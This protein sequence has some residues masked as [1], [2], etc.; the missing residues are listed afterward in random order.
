MNT[1]YIG[2]MCVARRDIAFIIS[3]KYKKR[4][5]RMGM[6]RYYPFSSDRPNR[7]IPRTILKNPTLPSLIISNRKLPT[8]HSHLEFCAWDLGVRL[9]D[10]SRTSHHGLRP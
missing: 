5:Y 6:K 8:I 7:S 4:Q 9:S 2:G 10:A 1:W 3:Y